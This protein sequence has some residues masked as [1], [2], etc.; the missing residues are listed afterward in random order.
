MQTKKKPM[1]LF[2]IFVSVFTM[3][4]NFAH[5][6]TPTLIVERGLDSSM[7]GV[8]VAAS[9]FA[10]FLFAP[11]WGNLCNYVSTRRIM[12]LASVG[13][14]IGQAI[15]GVAQSEA[16]VIA[17]RFFAGP[18][19]GAIF[20]C[21]SNY[22]LNVSDPKKR[23]QDLTTL[24]TIQ[25]VGS[26]L[27]YFVGGMFGLVSVEFTFVVQVLTLVLCGIMAYLVCEDDMAYRKKPEQPLSLKA[28][29][30][31]SAFATAKNFMTPNLAL[32]FVT[33]TIACIGYNSFE[34]CINYY[35]KDQ[36]NLSSA[37]NGTIKAVI[38]AAIFVGN[39]T[40]CNYLQKKTD[41][42]LSAN[43]VMI[44]TAL[45]LGLVL[46]VDSLWPMLILYV[47]FS[48]LNAIRM[49][50]A[51]TVVAD[52]A[53]PEYSNVVMGFFQ[54]MTALGSVFGALFAGLIYDAG[55]KLPFILAFVTSAVAALIY[56]VYV[57]RYK[58]EK[59]AKA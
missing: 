51:Q 7:F 20:V 13:Y 34:Q 17:G 26:A 40:I 5:P 53:A 16:V 29:N 18:F 47:V 32:L 57:S 15:F 43:P 12:L 31:F 2:W 55:P 4:A 42:N 21:C 28:A 50:L 25:T 49:P 52:N 3:A 19:S 27:G 35:I 45:S 11:F 14:A 39:S 59:A 10:Y 22:I 38:A 41:I 6:V 1:I 24:M 37:Y 8:A 30:P 58:K 54:S 9:L 46:L 44:L 23:G 36:F 33:I 56:M 48:V